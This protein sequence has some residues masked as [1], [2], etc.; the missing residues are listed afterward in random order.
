MDSIKIGKIGEIA[1][2]LEVSGYPK[3]GNVHRTHDMDDML[4]EDFLISSVSIKDKLELVSDNTK[5]FYP[6]L[7]NSISL[8][9]CILG[10][11]EESH[12]WTNTNTNLGIVMLLVPLAASASVIKNKNEINKI[13]N[14]LDVILKNSTVD[15]AIALVK[16]INLSEAGNMG[17]VEKFDVNNKDTIDQLIENKINMYDLLVMSQ[18]YDKLS[19]QLVNKLPLIMDIGLPIYRLASEKYSYNI[20]TIITYMSLLAYCPD[21]LISRKF[22][23]DTSKKVSN[24][25][26]DIIKKFDLSSVEGMDALKSFDKYLIDN[27]YNPGTTADF[28]AATLFLG[29][30]EKHL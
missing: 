14:I 7:L 22:G 28:T 30:L 17:N 8:G 9:S 4:Y 1:C 23:E 6:N 19:Y 20:S 2:L 21:T 24:K 29:L 15:D 25:A 26:K 3:P 5:R 12:Y 11:V 13:P 10:A 27:N 16:A 18:D